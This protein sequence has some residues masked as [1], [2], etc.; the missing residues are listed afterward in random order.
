MPK[1]LLRRYLPDHHKIRSHRHLSRFGSRLHDPN[2]WHLNRRSVAGA[3]AIGLFCA[4]L[5]IPGQMIVAAA[6]AVAAR[7]NLPMSVALVWLT[8]PVTMPP[9]YFFCYKVGAWLLG[10]PAGA[11]PFELSLTWIRHELA[12]VWEPFLLG[13]LVCGLLSAAAGYGL[14]RL[15]WRWHVVRSWEARKGRRQP[16]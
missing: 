14:I 7:V 1:R 3:A 13:S 10:L 11:E 2:L 12:S 15:I 9:V 5:P 16:D 8:N 4:F 6:L